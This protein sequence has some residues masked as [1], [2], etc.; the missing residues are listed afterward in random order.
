[1][2][3]SLVQSVDGAGDGSG[4][5][6]AVGAGSGTAVGAGSGTAVGTGSGTAVG[7]CVAAVNT[8]GNHQM[9]KAAALMIG[10]IK[11]RPACTSTNLDFFGFANRCRGYTVALRQRFATPSR[12]M[13]S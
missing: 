9:A 6:T 5:G 13:T 7:V 1:M 11:W 8:T 10:A 12:V 3:A 4:A 2:N